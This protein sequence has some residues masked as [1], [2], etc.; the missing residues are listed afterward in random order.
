MIAATEARKKLRD[1]SLQACGVSV[2]AYIS[3]GSGRVLLLRRAPGEFLQGFLDLPSGQVERGETIQRALSREVAEETG[4]QVK[5]VNS[6]INCFDYV[7]PQKGLVRQLN[8]T[9]RVL[10]P[11]SITLSKEHDGY[12]W[13]SRAEIHNSQVDWRLGALLRGY[14]GQSK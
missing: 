13:L 3:D 11:Y 10:A 4:L 9:V 2:G 8:F 6:F 5:V 1:H 12:I 7:L 14:F